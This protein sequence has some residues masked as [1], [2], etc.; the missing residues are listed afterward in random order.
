MDGNLPCSLGTYAPGTTGSVV[1]G[2]LCLHRTAERKVE[3]PSR[4]LVHVDK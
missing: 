1:A 2:A 4:M 3:S